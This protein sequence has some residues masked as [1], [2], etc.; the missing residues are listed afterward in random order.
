MR[1]NPRTS[2]VAAVVALLMT[3]TGTGVWFM[4]PSTPPQD[5]LVSYRLEQIEK[6]LEKIEK[7]MEEKRKR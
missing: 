1:D 4:R 6:R 5:P 3:G 2:I 7:Y